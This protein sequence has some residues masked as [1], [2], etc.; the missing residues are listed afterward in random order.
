MCANAHTKMSQKKRIYKQT[1]HSIK[2]KAI[3]RKGNIF[4]TMNKNSYV[5]QAW[6]HT[7]LMSALGRQKQ[8]DRCEFQVSQDCIVRPGLKRQ[9]A[10]PDRRHHGHESRAAHQA[11]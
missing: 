7:P 4:M 3:R 6:W 11:G 9:N 8:A 5:G 10:L 2:Y 1:D